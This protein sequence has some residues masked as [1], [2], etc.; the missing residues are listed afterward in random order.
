MSF[1]ACFGYTPC[2]FCIT[3]VN[4]RLPSAPFLGSACGVGN[5]PGVWGG[6]PYFVS[7]SPLQSVNGH[8]LVR[9]CQF[10]YP[11]TTPPSADARQLSSQLGHIVHILVAICD[12]G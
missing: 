5:L 10:P 1:I 2:K 11:S 4:F 7:N 12:S 8:L 6:R 3:D 9:D